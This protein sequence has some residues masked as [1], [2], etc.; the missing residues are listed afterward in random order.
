MSRDALVVGINTYG[1][2]PRLEAPAE[3]AEAI[4]QLL[5]S[6]GEFRVK[7]IPE[8][9]TDNTIHVGRKTKV[10]LK[11]LEEALVQLFLPEGRMSPDTA[12]FYFSGHGL[13][14]NRGI[15]EG[16]LATSDV[17]PDLSNWGLS[18]QWLRRL[19]EESPIPQQIIWLDCC[20]SGELLNFDEAN[21]GEKGKGRDRCFIAA[22][23][24]FEVSYQDISEPYSVLTKA[25]LQGL[26]PKR[27]PDR[28][29]TNYTLID[30]LNQQL[31]SETQ[32]PIFTNFGQEINL[33]RQWEKA[34]PVVTVSPNA[35]CPYKG[36]AYFDC[37]EEDPKYF[38]GRRA[39]T[40]QLLEK[41][42]QGNFLAVLGAS[43]SGKSSVVRAGLLHQLKLGRKLSGSGQWKILPVFRP[44]EHPLQSLAEAFPEPGLSVV[45]RATQLA[46]AEELIGVGAVGLGHLI[47][48]AEASRVVLVVDQFEEAFTLCRDSTERQQFF[49]CLLGALERTGDKLCLVLAMRADFFGKC[50]EQ[51]YGGLASKIQEHLVTVTPMSREELAQAIIEPA[52][53]VGLAV[54]PELV[55]QMIADVE[56]SPGSLP[57]L[58]YTLTELW[59]Q[60]TE[61]RLTVSAYT[62]LGGVKGTLQKRADEVYQ[63]LSLEEQQTAKRIF[64]ELTQLGEG[65]EDTRRR[66]LQRDLVTEQQSEA[67]VD[68]T[69]QKLADA[70]LVVTSSLIE[71]GSQ[72]GR[73]AVVDVA[74]EALIRHWSRLRQWVNENRDAL[75]KK[76]NIEQDAQEWLDKGKSGDYLLRG[77]KL[78]EAEN[79]LQDYSD[80][81][82]LSSLAKEFVQVSQ[83][84][85]RKV[86]TFIGSTIAFVLAVIFYIVGFA[87][88]QQQQSKKT[89]E[90]V[91]LSTDPTKIESALP[92]FLKEACSLKNKAYKSKNET[93]VVQALAYYRKLR[94]VTGKLRTNH[95]ER[96]KNH[97]KDKINIPG[98]WEKA[99][100]S[101]AEIIEEHRIPKLKEY[102]FNKHEPKLGK[103]VPDSKPETFEKQYTEGAL[104]T[105]Y[106]ILRRDFG[107]GADLNDDRKIGDEIEAD[108]MPCETLKRIEMLWREATAD[109]CGWYE[110][111]SYYKA[112]NCDQLGQETLTLLIF[113]SPAHFPVERL[114]FCKIPN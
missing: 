58:Q 111:N 71:K 18:L 109:R 6:S 70:K 28:W 13:R 8:A 23:R 60:R 9:V 91:F 81:V 22:S 24:E 47:A 38:Y 11:E 27:C 83:A 63:S 96:Y 106:L 44:G 39:L 53:N 16:F 33:T 26:D 41:V 37:N 93:D 4:A 46:K 110:Q 82:P 74:H 69:I 85:R 112:P 103:L 80:T 45:D 90:A 55:D 25:L 113:D 104:Q 89:I 40:D 43:G 49:E 97:V 65:T 34:A 32:R 48:A 92:D 5:T 72:S 75:R 79:F 35:I 12:L 10:T 86:Q 15:Q 3:D 73:V 88:W 61:E 64:L 14:K 84:D 67:L 99:E 107:A 17:N 36:L 54:E 2:L 21:P 19:L 77:A 20:Y 68:R 30:F 31:K 29:V 101:L 56:D 98:I 42:R 1:N 87:F 52:K 51:E 105:T 108:M 76:R 95:P 102:L 7:R 114:K 78:A 59:Q 100:N 62:H 94:E 50:A 57:L 66:V